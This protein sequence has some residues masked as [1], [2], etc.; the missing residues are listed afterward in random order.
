M[1]T[2]DELRCAAVLMKRA[3]LKGDESLTVAQTILKIEA[4]ARKLAADAAKEAPADD[5]SR[6]AE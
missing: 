6:P 4:M 1:L 3:P 2:F 5:D